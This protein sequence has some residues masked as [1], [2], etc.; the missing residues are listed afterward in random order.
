M[1]PS[2]DIRH[3]LRINDPQLTFGIWLALVIIPQL[4]LIKDIAENPAVVLG[5]PVYTWHEARFLCVPSFGHLENLDG[6]QRVLTCQYFGHISG[7]DASNDLH[8]GITY[9]PFDESLNVHL[10][11]RVDLHCPAK[12]CTKR[13]IRNGATVDELCGRH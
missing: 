5:N 11:K 3:V 1:D 8:R 9:A 2:Y 12:C 13:G 4:G 10:D 6:I 7:I